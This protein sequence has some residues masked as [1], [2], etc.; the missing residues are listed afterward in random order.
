MSAPTATGPPPGWYPDP[1][2]GQGVRW[3]DGL[4][5]TASTVADPLAAWNPARAA[6][7]RELAF[8]GWGQWA[9]IGVAASAV[10]GALL[11]LAYASAWRHYLHGFHQVFVAAENHQAAPNPPTLPARYYLFSFPLEV[12][13]IAS[14]V[15]LLVW[16]FRAASAAR[17]L[18][19]P[20]RHRPGWGIG[21]WFIPIANL[22]CPYQAVRDCLPAQD[23]KASVVMR[24][25]LSL[26]GAD[27]LSIATLLA[28]PFSRPA[29]VVLFCGALALWSLFMVLLRQVIA[30][31]AAD[32]RAAIGA[33][34]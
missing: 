20:A 14:Q 4:R 31:I 3:W 30:V 1:A 34:G 16:Q 15:V 22:F 10:L 17:I 13:Q 8:Y 5:W 29:G 24:F 32:H 12:L 11:A 28:S 18:G 21:F 26:L 7:E 6:V 23:R 27:G 9:A 25:W 33:A 2:G 19:Y